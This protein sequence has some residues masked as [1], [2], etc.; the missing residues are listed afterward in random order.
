L[1]GITVLISIRIRRGLHRTS[2][3]G[4]GVTS[5]I[6]AGGENLRLGRNKAL[7]AI[8]GKSLIERVMERVK[9][10]SDRTLI[11]ISP[12][13]S[14]LPAV[15]EAEVVAD[16]YPGR[17]PLG[18]IYTGL[19][20]SKSRR[21]L[22]VACDMPFLN[23][24]LLR[25]MIGLAQD[26]DVVVPRVEEGKVEPL[27]AIYSRSCLDS[28]KE[29]LGQ[30]HLKVSRIFNTVRVRYVGRVDCQRFDPQ[31]LSFFNVNRPSDLKRALGL[32]VEEK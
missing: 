25:Y 13:Q 28:M 23:V 15:C 24:E 6:L 32:A 27:H 30:N 20:N 7:E 12:G 31:L 2:N 29:L 11:V 3:Q 26:F 18:G 8:N 5:I 16:V 14:A 19:L 4:N 21:S 17:G 1:P 10:V 22:V 9:Q